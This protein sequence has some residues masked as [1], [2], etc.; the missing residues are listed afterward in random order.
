M[1]DNRKVYIVISAPDAHLIAK[2]ED[3][4]YRVIARCDDAGTALALVTDL[5]EYERIVEV[6][7]G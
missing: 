1:T 7:D 4:G 3:N 5:N 2:A 6:S